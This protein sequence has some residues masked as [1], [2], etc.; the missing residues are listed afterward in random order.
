MRPALATLVRATRIGYLG[1]CDP[2][3]LPWSVRPTLATLVRATHIG[4]LGPC[5][6]HWLP[7]SVRPTLA[8]LVRATRIGYLGSCDPHWL[9]WSVYPELYDVS[10]C[11]VSRETADWGDRKPIPE[12]NLAAELIQRNWRGAF[13]RKMMKGLHY[14]DSK[15]HQNTSE[16]LKSVRSALH[17]NVHTY[18][19]MLLRLVLRL[20]Q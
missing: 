6:P 4:Y 20:S 10:C 14:V 5:D 15:E 7:W 8:A 18:S 19:L 13:T 12:E 11:L 2:H 1:P 17:T 9:P 16:V 3:W